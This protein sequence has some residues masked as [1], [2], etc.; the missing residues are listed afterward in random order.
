MIPD[1]EELRAGQ[2][3]FIE[4]IRKWRFYVERM[5]S[6]QSYQARITSKPAVRG[7]FVDI[8]NFS[9]WFA[10]RD[11]WK[12]LHWERV[13]F[14]LFAGRLDV[15]VR[16]RGRQLDSERHILGLRSEAGIKRHPNSALPVY[17]TTGA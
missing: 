7:L 12:F 13:A 9:G 15:T 1:V 3:A 14:V 8:K 4:E 11:I 6:R 17:V 2:E 5:D 10:E 16:R